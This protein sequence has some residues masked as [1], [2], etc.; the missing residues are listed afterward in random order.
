MRTPRSAPPRDVAPG[1]YV[2]L[3]RLARSH[4][5]KSAC[6]QIV[7]FTHSFRA[8]A[9][10]PGSRRSAGGAGGARNDDV[11]A[12]CESRSPTGE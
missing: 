3:A 2:L 10:E 7:N 6:V 11:C 5:G 1:K 8:R 9:R 4:H 12:V